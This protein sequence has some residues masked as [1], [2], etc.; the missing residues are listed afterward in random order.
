MKHLKLYEKY[1]NPFNPDEIWG[2]EIE[3]RDVDTK[4]QLIGTLKNL[5]GK[6]VKFLGRERNTGDQERV[7]TLMDY[8]LYSDEDAH[9]VDLEDDPHFMDIIFI[10]DDGIQY[11]I[12]PYRKVVIVK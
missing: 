6:K 3:L 2:D 11:K 8:R 1:T 4:E 12:N 7:I 5:I 10:S 9:L